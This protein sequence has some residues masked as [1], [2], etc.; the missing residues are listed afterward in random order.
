MAEEVAQAQEKVEQAAASTAEKAE[1]GA[2]PKTPV[3]KMKKTMADTAEQV[4][5]SHVVGAAH[6]LALAGIGA[7]VLTK[8]EGEKLLST[9][10][11]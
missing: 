5:Q 8:E 2:A 10:E 3:D 4:Q 11:G 6:K 7:G 9:P 1:E